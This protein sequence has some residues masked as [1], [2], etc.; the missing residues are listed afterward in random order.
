VEAIQRAHPITDE[1]LLAALRTVDRRSFLDGS[2][3]LREIIATEPEYTDA[4]GLGPNWFQRVALTD[5]GAFTISCAPGDSWTATAGIVDPG[6]AAP[7]DEPPL[8]EQHRRG[9]VLRLWERSAG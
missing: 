1:R 3:A 8:W 7:A 9:L 2:A 6:T 4:G 5:P